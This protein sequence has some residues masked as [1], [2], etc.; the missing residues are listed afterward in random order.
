MAAAVTALD[1]MALPSVT[2]RHRLVPL[3]HRSDA[4]GALSFAQQGD[5]IP[6][7]VRRIFYLYDIAPGATRGGHAH[8]AQHQFLIMMAG[9]CTVTVDN[10]T[11]R[12]PIRLSLGADALYLP[13]LL[14]LD[15]GEFTADAVCCVLAS[16]L[17][18]EADYLR[19][20]EKFRALIQRQD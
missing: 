7:Q 3:A 19:N 8:L 10:G 15:L 9:A 4:R 18:A 13:P 17:Y 16:D 11:R 1:R 14:W 2:P 12:T 20:Y 6:F 5:Q